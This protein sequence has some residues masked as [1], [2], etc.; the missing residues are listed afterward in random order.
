MA[1]LIARLGGP[2][3]DP[4][5]RG[6]LWDPSPVNVAPV[7]ELASSHRDNRERL[8][9]L[10]ARWLPLALS[11][12]A[13]AN[14]VLVFYLPPSALPL[15]LH[16]EG[17]LTHLVHTEQP[18]VN[19]RFGFYLELDDATDGGE[20]V[21]PIDSFVNPD[22][23]EG[24]ADFEVVERDYDPSLLPDAIAVLAPLGTVETDDGDLPYSIIRGDD[25][26]WWLALT[27]DGVV[28]VPESVAPVPGVAP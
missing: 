7:S 28:V 9:F 22:L 1:G 2:T 6:K 11:L 14:L 15:L 17:S 20:L 27:D 10:Y 18:S 24:F 19:R 8:R 3:H 21:V 4:L 12:A 13:L 16:N 5:R 23:A 26:L 25:D